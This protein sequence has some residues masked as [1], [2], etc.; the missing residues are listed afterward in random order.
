MSPSLVG[1]K[2]KYRNNDN[3]MM[4]E[5]RSAVT[6]GAERKDT[7]YYHPSFPSHA[8]DLPKMQV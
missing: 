2:D 4:R 7:Q 5:R 1:K 3:P 8:H 6:T